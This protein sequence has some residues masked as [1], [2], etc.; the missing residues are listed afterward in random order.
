MPVIIGTAGHI[1]H[2][3]T[4]LIKALTGMDTDRLKEEKERGISIDLGFAYFDL[5]DGIR[6]GVVDV[7]GHERFIKNMLAGATGIDLVLFVVAADDGIMPQTREHLEIMHLLRVKRGIFIITKTDLVG[8]DRVDEATG[9]IKRLIIDTCL[10]GSPIIPVSSLTG[11]GME[12]LKKAIAAE[13]KKITPRPEGGFFRLP[14]DRSF[15]IKGFGTVVTGTVVSGRVKKGEE[16]LILPGKIKARVRGI[17]S[18]Y[19]AIDEA[20]IGQRIAINLA[21]VSHSSIERGD[22]LTSLDLIEGV[23]QALVSFEFLTSMERSLKNRARLKLHHLTNETIATVV[24]TDMKPPHP[25]LSPRWVGG[26]GPQEGFLSP[27]AS[28]E[29]IKVRGYFQMDEVKAGEGVYGYIRLSQ[30]LVM[31]RG[32]RFILRDPSVN[33]TLGGGR[34]LLPMDSPFIQH[35][36]LTPEAY[37]VLEGDN[38][39]LILVNL[40]SAIDAFGL[41]VQAIRVGLNLP[42]HA[43]GMEASSPRCPDASGVGEGRKGKDL[44][45]LPGETKLVPVELAPYSIRGGKQGEVVVFGD[46]AVLKARVE[47]GKGKIIQALT[48]YHRERPGEMGVEDG[49]LHKAV[50][51]KMPGP[52]LQGILNGLIKEGRVARSGNLFHL[53]SHRPV[54]TGVDKEIED[55]VIALFARRG[56]ASLKREDI[57]QALPLGTDLKSVPKGDMERVFDGLVKRGILV[58]VT[59]DGFLSSETLEKARAQLVNLVRKKG[60]VKA[61]EFRDSLGC[62]RK[63]A[64]EILDYFDKERFTLRQ[65]DFRTIRDSRF[66]VQDAS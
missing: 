29:R 15:S 10:A 37:Q 53:S 42:P 35:S 18:H 23:T 55:G 25:A 21:G 5:P 34:V 62:G 39:S 14:I 36:A 48:A 16:V 6:C 65:G 17:Q 45:Y 1:D 24:F 8:K 50:G 66:K 28:G 19:Q 54:V 58:K 3:K 40:L 63:L 33:K 51:L 47:E 57:L 64:I 30:P 27:D 31:M 20:T 26:R 13:V 59:E 43:F 44:T 46:Y 60:K 11:E 12:E 7:P 61:S 32:D 4:C 56:F 22:V 41:D 2:G 38:L 49:Y 9:M 52:I